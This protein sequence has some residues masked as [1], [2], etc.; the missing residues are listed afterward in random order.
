MRKNLSIL[1][2]AVVIS[3]CETLNSSTFRTGKVDYEDLD[4]NQETI[5]TRMYV[6]QGAVCDISSSSPNTLPA[7][8]VPVLGYI[9]KEAIAYGK[10][11]LDNY[12]E[13]LNSDVK[14]NASTL[15]SFRGEAWPTDS[16]IDSQKSRR[17][18]TI[19]SQLRSDV[20]EY[21]DAKGLANDS[22]ELNKFKASKEASIR[23]EM[24]KT[25]TIVGSQYDICLLVVA[26]KY[27]DKSKQNE[28]LARFTKSGAKQTPVKEY[29]MIV[30]G[31]TSDQSPAAFDNLIEDPSFVAEMQVIATDLGDKIQYTVRPTN[32]FYPYSL[33]KYT[34]SDLERKLSIELTFGSHKTATSFD[35]IKGGT[36]LSGDILI[37]KF[38][39]FE[40][41][42][43]EKYK[44]ISVM[45]SEGA[46][47]MPTAKVLTEISSHDKDLEKYLIDKISELAA[48]KGAAT[49]AAAGAAKK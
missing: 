33:H 37:S 25:A 19:A 45:V 22:V 12:A 30:P 16:Q 24:A 6:K 14:L 2:V 8:A 44:A 28:V 36:V 38:S 23:N 26:G 39:M 5:E 35:A 47:K 42:K 49:E 48:E 13:Y 11:K 20:S 10:S 21:Q 15:L 3:G 34:K 9:A 41:P 40:A 46:D 1:M 4:K 17:E 29:K 32:I 7:L 18:S 27:G 43:T 31:V